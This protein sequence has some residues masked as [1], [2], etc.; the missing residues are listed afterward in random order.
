MNRRLRAA[1]VM[2]AIAASATTLASPTVAATSAGTTTPRILPYAG[3]SELLVYGT[4]PYYKTLHNY[5]QVANRHIELHVLTASGTQQDLINTGASYDVPVSVVGSVVAIDNANNAKTV[6]W[7]DI[8]TAKQGATPLDPG[9]VFV[10]AAPDGF[11]YQRPV[12][13]HF[14]KYRFNGAVD[15]LG[16]PIKSLHSYAAV[17]GP[18]GLLAAEN[19]P[20]AGAMR[21]AYMPWS[22]PGVFRRL[23]DVGTPC[24][25]LTKTYAGCS[26][27]IL[28]LAGGKPIRLHGF[29]CSA[30]DTLFNDAL[31]FACSRLHRISFGGK[32]SRSRR[33][34]SRQE[35]IHAFHTLIVSSP[36]QSKL[37]SLTSINAKP[38]VLLTAAGG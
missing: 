23:H 30:P 31:V 25:D 29:A 11:I 22:H 8:A 7:W 24:S 13:G 10:G 37:M 34:Y 38:H 3:N 19:N 6:R 18:H 17:T 4:R 9:D 1:S 36:D 26:A 21:V 20:Q 16:V 12:D 32:H 33:V 28:P 5:F 15:D 14:F 35:V 27:D 2:A